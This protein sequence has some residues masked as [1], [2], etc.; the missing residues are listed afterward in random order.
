MCLS[1]YDV[2]VRITADGFQATLATYSLCSHENMPRFVWLS[3]LT[4]QFRYG[5]RMCKS[6]F[7]FSCTVRLDLNDEKFSSL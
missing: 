3:L 6:I 4:H 7:V 5:K 2:S 1:K